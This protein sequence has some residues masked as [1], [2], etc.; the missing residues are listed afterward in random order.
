MGDRKRLFRYHFC[1]HQTGYGEKLETIHVPVQTLDAAWQPNDGMVNAESAYCPYHLDDS[2]NRVY[3]AHADVGAESEYQSGAWNIFL[4]LSQDH[5]GF[6]GG[7]FTEKGG[8]VIRFYVDLMDRLCA[9]P[10]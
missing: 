5:F 1:Q 6:I 3:D 4:M 9:L 10:G 8:D 2:G 7:I